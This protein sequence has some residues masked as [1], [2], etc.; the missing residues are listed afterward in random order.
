MKI[1]RQC[2]LKIA[3]KNAWRSAERGKERLRCRSCRN[4]YMRART[5]KNRK[6]RPTPTERFQANVVVD[7]SG[8]WLWKG[9]ISDNGYG[10]FCVDYKSHRA[11]RWAYEQALGPIPKGLTLDH[12]CRCRNCVNPAHLEPVSLATNVMRGQGVSARNARK[13]HCKRGH[14]FSPEN[15]IYRASRNGN[16]GRSCRRCRQEY[17]RARYGR[18]KETT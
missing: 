13:T 14:E 1:C 8:C 6:P 2:G 18:K 17:D 11:H 4:A 5:A 16:R 7:A 12:L 10:R 9:N 15:T 3:D